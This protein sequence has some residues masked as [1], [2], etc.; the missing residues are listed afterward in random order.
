MAAAGGVKTAFPRLAAGVFFF[1]FSFPGTPEPMSHVESFAPF[2]ECCYRSRV[3]VSRNPK[4]E[5]LIAVP[6]R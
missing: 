1:F 5:V 6:K 3:S 2:L 4:A